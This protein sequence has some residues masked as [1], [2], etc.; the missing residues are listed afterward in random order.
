MLDFIDLIVLG[1]MLKIQS[2]FSEIQTLLSQISISIKQPKDQWW[3]NLPGIAATLALFISL[4]SI[5]FTRKTA[6][7]VANKNADIALKI[8]NSNVDVAKENRA[9]SENIANQSRES[10][11]KIAEVSAKMSQEIATMNA[12][13]NK[14]IAAL[15]ANYNLQLKEHEY[16]LA[17]VKE[18]S[19]KRAK[20]YDTFITVA[21]GFIDKE[22][23]T[24][25]YA[26]S[27]ATHC[28][29]F[30]KFYYNWMDLDYMVTW[31]TQESHLIYSSISEGLHQIH[32]SIPNNTPKDTNISGFIMKTYPELNHKLFEFVLQ[33]TKD[34]IN[35]NDFE[36]HFKRFSEPESK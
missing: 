9:S 20:I 33:L 24:G 28:D 30:Y 11:Q 15:N 29:T 36:D 25:K 5:W 35:L 18:V 23:R 2:E 13:F 10:A 4:V 6:L 3:M 7:D 32:Q 19:I 17:F 27:I 8:S 12:N 31:L 22:S 34:Y 26:P 1:E 21:T 16:R 14:E